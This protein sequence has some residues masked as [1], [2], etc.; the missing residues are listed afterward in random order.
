MSKAERRSPGPVLAAP[1][2]APADAFRLLGAGLRIE[3][4]DKETQNGKARRGQVV[5]VTSVGEAE[6]KSTVVANLAA[7]FSEVGEKA[8]VLSCDLRGP[9]MSHTLGLGDPDRLVE[10][11]QPPNGTSIT[12]RRL[13]PESEHP[14]RPGQIIGSDA[15][16]A[17]IAEAR[18]VADVVVLDTPPIGTTSDPALLLSQADAILLVAHA[19]KTTSDRAA[20]ADEIL[21][22]LDAPVAGVVL[23]AVVKKARRYDAYRVARNEE[24][25]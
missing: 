11:I 17:A 24:S 14:R 21:R 20:A 2:S 9:G 10:E 4:R 1:S 23:N 7:S 3:P 6:G 16:R 8:Y 22:R 13:V 25:A 19:G 5:M 15:T 12:V 18:A